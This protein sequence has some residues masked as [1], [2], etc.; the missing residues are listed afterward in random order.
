M[1]EERSPS[2]GRQETHRSGAILEVREPSRHHRH[3]SSGGGELVLAERNNF[4]SDRDINLEIRE[5]ERE[6]RALRV[7]R[8]SEDKLALAVRRRRASAGEEEIKA[9]EWFGR[10]RPVK[11]IV[12]LAEVERSR[13]DVIRIER[14]RKGRMALV[15]HAR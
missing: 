11:E 9:I 6:R 12:P 13:P 14:D 2:R 10:V 1:I 8:D 4:R 3:R 15:R 5:L 7:E